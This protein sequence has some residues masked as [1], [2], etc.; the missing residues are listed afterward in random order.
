MN[1][2]VSDLKFLC[3]FLAYPLPDSPDVCRKTCFRPTH[4]P[5]PPRAISPLCAALPWR[6]QNKILLLLEPVSLHG[7]WPAHLSGKSPR[8]GNLFAL[9]PRATLSPCL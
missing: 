1:E 6:L 3:G 5:D 8:C 9:A 2:G 7:F 4:R